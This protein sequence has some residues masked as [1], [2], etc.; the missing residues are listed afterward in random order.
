M[1]TN[2]LL[3]HALGSQLG[4]SAGQKYDSP[5]GSISFAPSVASAG[6]GDTAAAANQEQTPVFSNSMKAQQLQDRLVQQQQQHLMQIQ[7]AQHMEV[8]QQHDDMLAPHEQQLQQQQQQ[9]MEHVLDEQH[10]HHGDVS[11]AAAAAAAV[12]AQTP[13]SELTMAAAAAAA[14]GGSAA[15]TPT[16]WQQALQLPGS[17]DIDQLAG[18]NLFSGSQGGGG[19]GLH[20]LTP[21]SLLIASLLA[22]GNTP[23]EMFLTSPLPPIGS[24]LRAAGAATGGASGL[25]A[26]G[27]RGGDVTPV[28]L[29]IGGGG[30]QHGLSIGSGSTGVRRGTRGNAL[31]RSAAGRARSG[32]GVSA[33]CTGWGSGAMAAPAPVQPAAAHG[34][35]AA[36]ATPAANPAACDVAPGT[37]ATAVAAAAAGGDA[38][39][40]QEDAPASGAKA[41]T[42]KAAARAAAAIA[43]GDAGVGLL[44]A[45]AGVCDAGMT[46]LLAAANFISTPGF[47]TDEVGSDMLVPASKRT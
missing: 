5:A 28:L 24:A 27:L 11:T 25:R 33:L 6:P 42:D 14:A 7:Q 9:Q 40:R 22:A 39:N 35:P 38:A 36:A 32:V 4:L 15:P 37:A 3:A 8:E 1:A 44:H 34:T 16:F 10:L 30:L 20:D 45:D 17:C 18:F 23:T 13:L 46:S 21:S 31:Q 47:E 43:A 26:P 19:T 29:N 2:P 41:D 12:G